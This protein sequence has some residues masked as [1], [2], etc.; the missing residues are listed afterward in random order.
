MNPLLSPVLE[1]DL[2]RLRHLFGEWRPEKRALQLLR[3][4]LEPVFGPQSAK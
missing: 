3:Q 4:G 1:S 2:Q